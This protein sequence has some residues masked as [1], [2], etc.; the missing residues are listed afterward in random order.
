[1]IANIVGLLVVGLGLISGANSGPKIGEFVNAF[2]PHHISGPDAGTDTCPV[3]KYGNT[4]AVQVWIHKRESANLKQVI[5]LLDKKVAKNPSKFKAFVIVLT[6]K[7]ELQ[8]TQT[9]LK[10]LAKETGSKGVALTTLDPS[11]PGVEANQ[12]NISDKISNT[13]FV[14]K[15]RKVT[16][17]WVDFVASSATLKAL[18]RA[19]TSATK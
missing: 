17:N 7:A 18:D 9:W 4:P 8:Q 3:C 19:I 5:Q 14:Y 13:V 6:P 16:A 15:N 12:I 1:M 10:S 11:D 2:E